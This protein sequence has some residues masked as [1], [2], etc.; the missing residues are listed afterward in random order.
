M[1]NIESRGATGHLTERPFTADG[2]AEA[3][4]N[5][6][7]RDRYG[8]LTTVAK[9]G[10]PVPM[11]VWFRIDGVTVTVYSQPHANRITHIFEH[12]DVSLHL[13]SDG[14]GSDIVIIG[15]RAAV[16]AEGVDPREDTKYWAKYH[17]EADVSGLSDA[18]GSF[19][20][21][22]TITPTTIWTTHPT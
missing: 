1:S 14:A 13:E 7:T 20:T 8:W 19:S 3:V 5:R 11:L 4:L 16:T 6:L 17:V 12:P 21:R 22:I 18:I 10:M 9:S 2:L 15:G